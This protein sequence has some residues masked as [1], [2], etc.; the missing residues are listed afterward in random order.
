MLFGQKG[1]TFLCLIVFKKKFF[2]NSPGGGIFPIP[3]PPPAPPPPRAS[4]LYWT[5]LY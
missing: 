4:M 5:A 3:L 1:Y 2:E